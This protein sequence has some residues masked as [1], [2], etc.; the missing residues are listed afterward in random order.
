MSPLIARPAA[1]LLLPALAGCAPTI[2]VF[3]LDEPSPAPRAVASAQP[4]RLYPEDGPRCRYAR[5]ARVTVTPYTV[6]DVLWTE[7]V[8]SMLRA[9]ARGVGADAVIGLRLVTEDGDARLV[10]SG[11]RE[12]TRDSTRSTTTVA[13]TTAVGRTR[14]EWLEGTAV[15]FVEAGCRE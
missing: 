8:A 15:R 14:R 12:R 6:G 11:Q 4:V 5:V 13:E 3:P 7:E 1:L 2:D 10:T 9:R